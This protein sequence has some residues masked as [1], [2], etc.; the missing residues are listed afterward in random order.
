M[1]ATRVRWQCSKCARFLPD[2]AV[3][4]TGMG[5]IWADCPRCGR[6]DNPRCVDVGTREGP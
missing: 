3:K 5:H 6:T 1:T 4:I 2:S